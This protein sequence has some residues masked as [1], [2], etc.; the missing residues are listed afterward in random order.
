MEQKKLLLIGCGI[1]ANHAHLPAIIAIKDKITLIAIVD[2]SSR[3]KE[4]KENL[5]Q[6]GFWPLPKLI[7]IPDEDRNDGNC[8][9]ITDI[10]DAHC[11]HANAVILSTLGIERMT[12]I[13][14]AIKKG[15]DI[16]TEKP[17]TITPNCSSDAAQAKK[18]SADFEAIQEAAQQR[19]K[20][21]MV[22]A[23]RRYQK[24]YRDMA[25]RVSQVFQQTGYG[26]T[27]IQ[28]LTND[29]LWHFPE[30][31]EAAIS[32]HP[33]KSGGGKLTHT[34]YHILD[35]TS[36]LMRFAMDEAFIQSAIVYATGFFPNDSLACEEHPKKQSLQNYAEVNAALQIS[37]KNERQDTVCM[38]QCGM[39]HEGLSHRINEKPSLANDRIHTAFKG[40]TKQDFLCLYQGPVGGIFHRRIAKLGNTNGTEVGGQDHTNVIYS[41]NPYY[42]NFPAVLEKEYCYDPQDSAPTM[43]FLNKITRKDEEPLSVSPLN[44]HAIAI[45]LLSA[46]YQSLATKAPVTVTFDKNEWAAPPSI[47]FIHKQSSVAL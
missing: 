15:M 31:Y 36:W 12:Y 24:S 3:M 11:S 41:A 5:L 43:E 26:I 30:D 37:F 22:V 23:Q 38:M 44:D 20:I 17:L 10:L 14:W 27:F 1:Q 42:S 25:K 39:L 33:T 34:G 29:G 35:T 19:V 28:C 32:Y 21:F 16:L 9:T 45:K 7:A 40:R 47:E 13:Q 2:M 4:I 46:S 18:I 6:H 8:N